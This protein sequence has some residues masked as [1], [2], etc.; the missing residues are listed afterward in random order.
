MLYA[1]ATLDAFLL[2]NHAFPL[3]NANSVLGADFPAGVR[4][5]AL[6]RIRHH[7]LLGW[8]CVAGKGNDVDQGRLIV[9]SV[10]YTHLDVYKR[11]VP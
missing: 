1:P 2:V 11:Q 10:S 4:Q 7:D 8:A 6:A 9:F 5:A 3:H